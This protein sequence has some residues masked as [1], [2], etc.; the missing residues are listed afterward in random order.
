MLNKSLSN[1]FALFLKEKLPEYYY[2]VTY[3]CYERVTR[4]A[5]NNRTEEFEPNLSS[6]SIKELQYNTFDNALS[7]A[8]GYD[9]VYKGVPRRLGLTTESFSLSADIA[10]PFI[11]KLYEA[12]RPIYRNKPETV[13]FTVNFGDFMDGN[14]FKREPVYKSMPIK[15]ATAEIEPWGNTFTFT[16]NRPIVGTDTFTFEDFARAARRA[17]DGADD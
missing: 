11:C 15:T 13:P 5:I 6:F 4:R 10:I 2:S 3:L 7:V 14:V 9:Y 8:F 12:C 17:I 16:N 1:A